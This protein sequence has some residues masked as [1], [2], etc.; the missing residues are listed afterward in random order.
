MSTIQP[1]PEGYGTVT[2]HIVVKDG[3]KA[4]E[5]YKKAFGAEERCAFNGPDGKSFM[6]GEIKIG[7][8]ILMLA[9]ENPQMNAKTA[10]TLGGTP[11][12]LAL[13][14]T[15][16]D[17]SFKRATDAGAK[18]IMPPADMFWGDRYGQV[19]DP[20]GHRW[21]MATP[22]EQVSPEQM[23]ERLSACEPQVA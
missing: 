17:K 4:I 16:V 21:S 6:H 10:N 2:P 15:D 18:P 19:V 8:S 12:T 11:V 7:S 9:A 13:Y 22:V 20:F 5:F 3:R 1:I 14:V 23:A